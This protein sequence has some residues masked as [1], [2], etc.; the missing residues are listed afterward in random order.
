MVGHRGLAALGPLGVHLDRDHVRR[1]EG[2]GDELLGVVGVLD[3][4]DLLSP[5]LLHNGRNPAA[6]GADTGADRV[7]VLVTAPNG[8]FG[9]AARLAGDGLDLDGA[10][11][12]LGGLHLKEALDQPR[13]GAGDHDPRALL[14][15]DHVH[16]IDHHPLALAQHLAGDLLA[17][18]EDGLALLDLQRDVPLDGVHLEHRGRDDLEFLILIFLQQL[19][20]LRLADALADDVLGRLRRDPAEILG[21]Q[22][23]F[24][25]AALLHRG[26]VL[27][28]VLQQDFGVGVLDLLDRVLA[29]RDI[30]APAVRVDLDHVLVGAAHVPLD[31]NGDGA[32]DLLDERVAGNPLLLLQKAQCLKKFGVHSSLAPPAS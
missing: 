15:R 18:G 1:G 27:V 11:L 32:L 4:V 16:H 8:H 21:L 7:H 14:G 31:C 19:P 9:T 2:R 6:L 12:D 22:R 17:F 25:L 28:G 10:V 29:H 5:E 24:D 20:A 30:E 13:M 26:V 23:D 3:H